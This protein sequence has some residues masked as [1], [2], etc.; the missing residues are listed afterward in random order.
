MLNTRV[1]SIAPGKT[2]NQLWGLKDENE[3]EALYQAGE[4]VKSE[5]VADAILFMLTRP[6]SIGVRDLVLLPSGRA[7]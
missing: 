2:L 4:G 3:I 1:G 5:D 7:I 6:R